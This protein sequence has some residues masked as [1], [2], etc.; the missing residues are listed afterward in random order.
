MLATER[1]CGRCGGRLV[2]GEDGPS[3]IT[4]GY[5]A[6][7][8]MTLQQAMEEAERYESRTASGRR[9]RGGRHAA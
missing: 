1:H 8:A 9:R 7:P 5:V 6:Y 4:C 3:C 2:S